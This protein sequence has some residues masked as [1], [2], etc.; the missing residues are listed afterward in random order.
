MARPACG[1]IVFG[2]VPMSDEIPATGIIEKQSSVSSTT[3]IVF[4]LIFIA[5]LYVFVIR[6][7][8]V[9]GG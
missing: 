1:L 3:L 5:L 9:L 6:K 8:G 4:L 7:T 2:D